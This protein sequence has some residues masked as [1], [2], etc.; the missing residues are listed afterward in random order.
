MSSSSTPA[1]GV[2]SPALRWIRAHRAPQGGVVVSSKNRLLYPE[3]TG[4]LVPTL[5]RRGE[6]ELALSFARRLVSVQRDDGLFGDPAGRASYAFDTGQVLRGFVAALPYAPDLAEPLRRAADALVASAP[7]GRLPVPAGAEWS[8]GARGTIPEAVHLYVLPALLAASDALG[9]RAWRVFVAKSMDWYARNLELAEFRRPNQ[10]THLYGYVMEAL[11]DL[12]AGEL[13]AIGMKAVAESQHDTGLVPAYHDVPWMCTPGQFQS[14]LVWAKLGD[15]TRA[16]RALEF[17]RP[18]R[19][20][21]G[22]FYGS[23]GP[24]ADYFAAE[25]PSWIA[26]FELDAEDALAAPKPAARPTGGATVVGRPAADATPAARPAPRPTTPPPPA[27]SASPGLIVRPNPHRAPRPTPAPAAKTAR[28]AAATPAAASPAPA[29]PAKPAAPRENLRPEAWHDAIKGA[30]TP[31]TVAARVR[32]GATPAWLAPVLAATRPG[33]RTLELGSG[34]GELSAA[35]ALAGR[36]PTCLD[37]SAASL[38]F[39]REVF[40]RVGR[41]GAFT[42]ADVTTTLPFA[43]G[44]FDVVWSSGLLEHFDP[45]TQAR[46]VAESARVARGAVVALVPNA[47]SLPYRLGKSL[48]ERAGTWTWGKEDPFA[49]LRPLFEA[50]GLDDVVESTI[51]AEHALEFLNGTTAEPLKRALAAWY[52]TLPAA[53]K[54]GLGQGYLLVAVGRRSSAPPPTPRKAVEESARTDATPR[55]KS[56]L[57]IVPND[58]L[59]AY[60]DA[61]Y[62]DLTEYFNPGGHFDEVVCLSPH[63]TAPGTRYGARIV[64]TRPQDFARRCAEFGV[65]AIRAY[66][67]PSAALIDAHRP[68]GV[69]FVVSVHDVDPSRF[70]PR[71]PAADLWLPVSGA[72]AETLRARGADATRILPF[73][74]RVDLNVFRPVDDPAAKAAF[75]ARFG[76]KYRIL[77][78]GRHAR[79]KNQ[80]GVVAALRQ[81]GKDYV[82]IFVGRGDVEG[83]KRFAVAAGVLDRCRFVDSVPNAELAA[84]YAFADAMVTPSRWEGFGVVFAEAAACGAAIVTTDVAPMNEFLA[85][86]RTALL[87]R[88]PEDADALAAAVREACEN[89]AVRTTLRRQAR[90]AAA[91]FAK[92]AVDAREVAAYRRLLDAPRASSPAPAATSTPSKIASPAPSPAPPPA[93]SPFKVHLLTPD[94]AAAWE[95]IVLASPD[96]WLYHTLDE[97]ALLAEA[98]GGESLSF[99]VEKAGRLVGVLPLQRWPWDRSTLWSTLMGPAG[100]ALIRDLDDGERVEAL[101]FMHGVVAQMLA[102]KKAKTVRMIL[103]P[104]APARRAEW[105]SPENPLKAFGYADDST[106]T[107]VVDLLPDE[108]TIFG[109]FCRAYRNRIRKAERDGIVVE[110]ARGPEDVDAYYALHCATYER[111]GVKPHPKAY[112]ESIYRRFTANGRCDLLFAKRDGR[113]ISA[114]NVATYGDAALYW[115]GANSVEGLES[116]A[117]KLLHWTAM[118]RAKARGCAVYETGEVFADPESGSK[119]EGLSDFKRRFGGDLVPFWKGVLQA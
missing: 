90:S 15:R 17:V 41:E 8:L 82:A 52:G 108:E 53:E 111:T 30:E 85:H 46:I 112:F 40:G 110:A 73:S 57:A 118:K 9:E 114:V 24:G 65:T 113:P 49:T 5:L 10:L 117:A 78:V 115:T 80:D 93:E 105:A 39:A 116:G 31:A 44:A 43:D 119:H 107:S 3:V 11:I 70:P 69:P 83:T 20:G 95:R 19:N 109:G 62:P 14:A 18:L 55:T 76:G 36:V 56:V 50:A 97:Q 88:D 35:L 72:C 63:E 28:P 89:P 45:A 59:K 75:D 66:D 21:S 96:A 29:Q 61:G 12:G 68:P 27:A 98:W 48:Q 2:E 37:F 67:L 101:A 25:E 104:L 84:Y 60:G 100:P 74:N 7:D 13:A 23:Y 77:C 58:P 34:T 6:R 64:P 106:W 33:D 16:R 32:D 87:V 42:Q 91:P 1:P 4:Y 47:R 92:E 26:K 71:L 54:D 99:L 86:G 81:L 51:A 79:Q 103:P 102:L 94:T 22:G 38:A